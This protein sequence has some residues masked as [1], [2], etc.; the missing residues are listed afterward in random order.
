MV[1]MGWTWDQLQ[2]TPIFVLDL[3]FAHFEREAERRELHSR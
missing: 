1:Q 3:L 2:S